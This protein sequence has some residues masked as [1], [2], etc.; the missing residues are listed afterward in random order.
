MK[1]RTGKFSGAIGNEVYVSSKH[2]QVVRSRPRRP[3]PATPDHQRARANL[4]H[5]AGVWRTLSDQQFAAW[6]AASKQE[7]MLPYRYFCQINHTLAAY[8]QPRLLDPP[9]PSRHWKSRTSAG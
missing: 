9:I 6:A 8:G 7:G 1:V 3:P 2:G 4:G 5:V